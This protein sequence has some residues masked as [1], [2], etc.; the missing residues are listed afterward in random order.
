[1]TVSTVSESRMTLAVEVQYTVDADGLPSTNQL[2]DW[3]LAAWRDARQDVEVVVRVTGEAESRRLNNE[4]RGRDHATNVLSFPY[5]PLPELDLF[6]V[7][8][9]VICAPVVQREADEQ[10]KAAD[11]HWAHMVVHGMLHLQGF[12][13]VDDADAAVMEAAETEILTGLGFPAPY[14]DETL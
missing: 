7:G 9:L 10:H 2:H 4:Y 6:H 12:D 1:M 11:A 3:A 5:D 14:D 8:D 13:H